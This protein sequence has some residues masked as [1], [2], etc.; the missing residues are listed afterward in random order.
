MTLYFVL[1]VIS[2]IS[3]ASDMLSAVL[4]LVYGPPFSRRYHHRLL[5]VPLCCLGEELSYETTPHVDQASC[6]A[7]C[8]RTQ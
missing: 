5:F 2:F 1:E 7:L 4:M 6:V 8:L 3:V